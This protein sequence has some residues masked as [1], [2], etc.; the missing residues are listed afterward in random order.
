MN[1]GVAI[2]PQDGPDF[3]TLLK[4]FDIAMYIEK[5]KVKIKCFFM[6]KVYTSYSSITY[7]KNLPI[8]IIKLEEVTLIGEPIAESL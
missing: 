4:N 8:Y 3:D 2:F 6:K 5:K 1:I 7:L